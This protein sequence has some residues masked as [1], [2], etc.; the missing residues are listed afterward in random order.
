MNTTAILY[1][2]V[3]LMWW[4]VIIFLLMCYRRLNPSLNNG[5]RLSEY[6]VGEPDQLP[7]YV[8]QANR[9]IINLFEMPVLYYVTCTVLFIT[10][11]VDSVVVGLAWGYVGLRIVHSLI[12]VTYNNVHHRS[13]V[14]TASAIAVA[15]MMVEMT[16]DLL[17]MTS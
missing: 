10:G 17:A 8:S 11:S 12:H 13:I 16:R 9:N 15:L 1:P 6:K 2:M 5:A 4:S 3:A 14:F 7:A